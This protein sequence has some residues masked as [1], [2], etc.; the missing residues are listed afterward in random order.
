MPAFCGSMI[1][2]SPFNGKS[3]I[4]ILPALVFARTLKGIAEL[5]LCPDA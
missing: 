4:K 3:K 1:F 2:S 5:F